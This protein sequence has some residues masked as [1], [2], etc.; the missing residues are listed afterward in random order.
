MLAFL[1]NLALLEASI[2]SLVFR[3]LHLLINVDT[4]AANVTDAAQQQ[5]I[6]K[7]LL[8]LRKIDSQVVDTCRLI[9]S[10]LSSQTARPFVSDTD[11]T[12]FADSHGNYRE[13]EYALPS[14][15]QYLSTLPKLESTNDR[16]NFSRVF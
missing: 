11:V 1:I 12:A 2:A 9:V 7:A 10:F 16:I 14:L 15:V 6:V 4:M 3:H 13:H 5:N 8:D